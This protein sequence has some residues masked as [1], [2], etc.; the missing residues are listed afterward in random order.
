MRR[1]QDVHTNVT[2]WASDAR[3]KS[4]RSAKR[5]GVP[6]AFKSLTRQADQARGGLMDC[7]VTTR[8]C[9]RAG[10]CQPIGIASGARVDAAVR[11][12]LLQ[13]GL[14]AV[15]AQASS[16]PSG[17]MKKKTAPS[18]SARQTMASTARVRPVGGRMRSLAELPTFRGLPPDGPWCP[19]GSG[20]RYGG[21]TLGSRPRG[22]RATPP[23]PS[24]TASD[25]PGARP[26]PIPSIGH[27]TFTAE[28]C[29]AEVLQLLSGIAYGAA[30]ASSDVRRRKSLRRAYLSET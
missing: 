16:S 1:P 8:L 23:W 26:S 22:P 12:G 24:G 18:R 21:G 15:S 10:K 9:P 2:S 25:R 4:N 11:S 28:L 14:R 13:V 3:W 20:S 17:P 27:E 5:R 29:V 6:R 30:A 7:P 19:S